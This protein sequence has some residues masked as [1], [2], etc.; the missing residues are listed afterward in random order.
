M[1]KTDNDEGQKIRAPNKLGFPAAQ[2]PSKRPAK[3]ASVT[4]FCH[5]NVAEHLY[6]SLSSSQTAH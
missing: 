5:L 1:S 6:V 2:P 4:H 3:E